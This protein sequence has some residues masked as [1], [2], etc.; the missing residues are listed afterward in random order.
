MHCLKCF[1]RKV[2]VFLENLVFAGKML[3]AIW[4]SKDHNKWSQ[5][6]PDKGVIKGP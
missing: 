3:P 1:F 2:I 4:E 6:W 5:K